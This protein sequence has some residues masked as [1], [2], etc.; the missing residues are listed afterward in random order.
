MRLMLRLPRTSSYSYY[1]Y[2]QVVVGKA[3]KTR[4]AANHEE[5]EEDDD[6][7]ENELLIG[8]RTRM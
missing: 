6:E 8:M 5:E 4:R 1:S 3:T 7:D 2:K